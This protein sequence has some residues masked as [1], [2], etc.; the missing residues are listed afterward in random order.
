MLVN[1][2]SFDCFPIGH[3]QWLMESN[4][5]SSL[6]LHLTT[7]QHAPEKLDRRCGILPALFVTWSCEESKPWFQ[8]SVADILGAWTMLVVIAPVRTA[9]A[10]DP[11]ILQS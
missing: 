11:A 9:P 8:R 6:S 5:W 7:I 4:A 3:E 2:A 10:K 1:Q